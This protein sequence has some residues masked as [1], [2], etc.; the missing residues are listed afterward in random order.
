MTDYRAYCSLVT[1]DY[2]QKRWRPAEN[3]AHTLLVVILLGK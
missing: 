1:V 3:I 2:K